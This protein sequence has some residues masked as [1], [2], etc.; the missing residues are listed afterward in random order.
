MPIEIVA[1]SYFG[2]NDLSG[3]VASLRTQHFNEWRL[4]IVDNSVDQAE[5]TKIRSLQAGDSR[6]R[7][8][9]PK[10]NLG[11]FGGARFGIEGQVGDDTLAVIVTNVDITFSGEETLGRIAKAAQ[12]CSGDVGVIAPRIVS[13]R[14]GDDQN[15]HLLNRPSVVQ[16]RRRMRRMSSPALAQLVIMGSVVKRVLTTPLKRRALTRT[17]NIYAAHGAFMIFLP[18]YFERGGDL[19]HPIFLFGEELTVAEKSRS[20]GLRTAYMTDLEVRHVEHGQMGFLRSKR[21]LT[22]MVTA[23]K[24][25]YELISR[26]AD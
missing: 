6:I 3:F 11:Y 15:P 13:N 7:I 22:E 16:Q 5:H 20:L 26:T 2:S 9:A 23:A 25:G 21:V 24:Y 18:E 10:T 8:L 19:S 1:I 12:E 17:N 14:S 4:T